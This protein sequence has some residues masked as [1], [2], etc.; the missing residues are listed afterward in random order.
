MPDMKKIFAVLC[1]TLWLSIALYAQNQPQAAKPGVSLN[2]QK[3][4]DQLVLETDPEIA[5]GKV[6]ILRGTLDTSEQRFYVKDISVMQPVCVSVYTDNAK[7][8]VSIKLTKPSWL[9]VQTEA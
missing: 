9:D 3:K 5:N 6:A 4:A 2:D 1:F 7:D 8:E